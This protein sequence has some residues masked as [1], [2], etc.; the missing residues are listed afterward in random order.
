MNDDLPVG[1]RIGPNSSM[2][3][4]VKR[5]LS[6]AHRSH[7]AI[8]LASVAA[9][10]SSSPTVGSNPF[11]QVHNVTEPSG[12]GFEIIDGRVSWFPDPVHVDADALLASDGPDRQAQNDAADWLMGLLAVGPMPV[13]EIRKAAEAD[14]QG[15]RTIE[16]AKKALGVVSRRDGYGRTGRFTWEL[17]T[18]P[19]RPPS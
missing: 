2:A 14:C 7:T 11:F 5:A 12:I 17:P 13:P 6:P 4:E 1:A 19:D 10:V 16:R 8:I 9:L 15:W 18:M 3:I